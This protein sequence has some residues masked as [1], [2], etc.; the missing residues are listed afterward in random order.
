MSE[1]FKRRYTIFFYYDLGGEGD[2]GDE[3][4]WDKNSKLF[5]DKQRMVM[6]INELSHVKSA[7]KDI[8]ELEVEMAECMAKWRIII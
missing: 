5:G 8:A 7:R 3:Q 6:A 2:L 4:V 1:Y